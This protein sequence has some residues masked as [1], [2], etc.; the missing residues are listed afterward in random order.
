MA[1]QRT[2]LRTCPFRTHPRFSP[3]SIRAA[4]FPAQSTVQP[5]APFAVCLRTILAEA[6]S[7]TKCRSTQTSK[8]T[9]ASSTPVS[10]PK[11]SSATS[12]SRIQKRTSGHVCI[13]TAARSLAGG[14]TSARTFRHISA[15]GNSSAM[16]AASA[17]C[18]STISSAMQKFILATS[19][20]SALVVLALHDKTHLHGTDSVACALAALLM[21][22]G[23]R[24][25]VADQRSN[26]RRWKSV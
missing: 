23:D 4:P 20:T 13:K 26:V 17:L 18:G 10:P 8:S 19:H 7:M 12:A 15:T 14:K 22:C 21:L 3:P 24:Q 5:T 6:R 16:D 1:L 9:P 25:S 2:R 11:K